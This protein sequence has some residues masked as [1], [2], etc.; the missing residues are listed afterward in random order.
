MA[1]KY[2]GL[3]AGNVRRS[4]LPHFEEACRKTGIDKLALAGGCIQ[5][6]LANGKIFESVPIKD[7]YIPPSAHDSGTAVGAAYWVW[8]QVLCNRRDFII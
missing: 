2:S 6:S 1:S 8:N 3:T 7:V 5:N 4:F